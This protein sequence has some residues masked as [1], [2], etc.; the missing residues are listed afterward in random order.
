MPFKMKYKNLEK[1]VDELHNASKMHKRQAD[2]VDKHIDKMQSPIAK[3]ASDAQRKAIHASKAEKSPVTFKGA[4]SSNSSCWKG[5]KKVG[6]KP[7]PSGTG[8]TVNDC[9]KI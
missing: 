2:V 4:D 5:Y 9:E 3:Y 1:V 7:S 8:K 6:T